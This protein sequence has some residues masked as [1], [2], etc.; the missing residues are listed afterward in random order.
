[1]Q[2]RKVACEKLIFNLNVFVCVNEIQFCLKQ[3]KYIDKMHLVC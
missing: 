1:M 3:V 2:M